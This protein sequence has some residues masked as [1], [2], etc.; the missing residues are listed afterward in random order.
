MNRFKL[1]VITICVCSVAY[2]LFLTFSA[3]SRFKKTLS[4]VFGLLAVTAVLSVFGKGFDFSDLEN[5]FKERSVSE[6]PSYTVSDTAAA[7]EKIL[8]SRAENILTAAGIS[9][10]K[11]AVDM[12]ID[13]GGSIIINKAEVSFDA[14]SPRAAEAKKLLREQMQMDFEIK[15]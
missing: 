10:K 13:G 14:G 11:V 5:A 7:V 1:A 12:D 2:S 3:G 6:T 8:E 4:T 15:S 9:F